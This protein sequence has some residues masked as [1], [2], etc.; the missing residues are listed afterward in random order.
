M[1][2]IIAA[3]HITL[4][5]FVSGPNE[6]M[7]CFHP[8]DTQYIEDNGVLLDSTDYILFGRVT[9]Q[10]MTTYWPN[11]TGE[12]AEKVNT[13]PKIVVSNTLEQVEWGTWGNAQ[14][15]NGN[16]EEE[17]KKIKQQDGGNIVIFG[18]ANLIQSFTDLGL[19]DEYRFLVQPVVIGSGRPFFH[20]IKDKL[21]LQ[22]INTKT[23]SS[24]T[25]LLNYQLLK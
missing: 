1:K 25:V 20:N 4:D 3:V 19:I 22:L 11:A 16:V 8:V 5:G 9:Y 6:D 12:F 13:I 18:S 10:G 23:Y 7:S 15:V 2:K 24:G 21:D 17:I 14:L